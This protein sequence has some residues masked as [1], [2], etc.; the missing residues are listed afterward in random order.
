MILPYILN[1]IWWT[2][3]IL[4]EN[5]SGN[6]TFDLKIYL[7]HSDLYF[8]VQWFFFFFFALKNILDL[9]AKPDSGELCCPVTAL[10]FSCF[11]SNQ[12]YKGKWC[13]HSSSFLFDQIIIRVAG[14]QD[15]HKSSVEFDFG[16]NQTIHFGVTC[17]WATKISHFWTWMS[18]EPVGQSWSNF[19]CSITGVGER[20]HK[21]WGRL[22]QNWFP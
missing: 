14:N 20:L 18:L 13:L 15:R 1:S 7:G 21:V 16:L 12:T 17:P 4:L 9:L 11:W 19:M 5:E 10:I 3:V 6:T 22:D 8:M 2:N